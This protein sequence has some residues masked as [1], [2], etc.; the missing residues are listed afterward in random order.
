MAVSVGPATY[1]GGLGCFRA[2]CR[3]SG[4]R[5]KLVG[6]FNSARASSVV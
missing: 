1:S 2:A 4:N 3:V 5:E 6:Y